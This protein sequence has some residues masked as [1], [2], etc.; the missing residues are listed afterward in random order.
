[1]RAG[2]AVFDTV[3]STSKSLK[4]RIRAGGDAMPKVGTRLRSVTCST[5]II[6]VKAPDG[7]IDLRCGGRP[8]VE[9]GGDSPEGAA[10]D[11]AH[12]AG[13]LLGKRYVDAS[14]D[15]EVLCTKAGDGSLSLGGDGLGVKEAKPLPASD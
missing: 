2:G 3:A 7:E 9:L 8:M 11:P 13:T 6:V 10:P 1:M 5:E 15:V 12:A 14:G 4:V